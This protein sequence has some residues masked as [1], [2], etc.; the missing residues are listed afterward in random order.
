MNTKRILSALLA[1]ALA[2]PLTGCFGLPDL[3]DT[4]AQAEDLAAR[5]QDLADTFSNVEW[6]KISRLVV[7]DATT[8]EVLGEVTDQT[9]IEHAFSPLSGMNGF[10]ETPTE[11]AEYTFELWQPETQKAG[12]S[13]EDLDEVQVLSATTYQDSSVVTLE[14]SPIGLT[15]HLAAQDGTA[16]A[17]R[18]LVS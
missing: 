12:Q 1:G 14:V 7:K 15:L 4:A 10:A 6:G 5:A 11:P 9:A 16:E 17:L 18:S 8:G 3:A 2:L 13:A